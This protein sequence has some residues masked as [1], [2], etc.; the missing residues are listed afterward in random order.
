MPIVFVYGILK[1]LRLGYISGSK[2]RR[3]ALDGYEL[4][5][6]TFTS[7]SKTDNIL[8]LDWTVQTGS[9]SSNGTFE[10]SQTFWISTLDRKGGGIKEST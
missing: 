4:M 9:L 2:Y 8:N 1:A 10:V 7:S 6:N 5:V 3:T